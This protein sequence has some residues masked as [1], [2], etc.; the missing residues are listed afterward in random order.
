MSTVI[1]SC[2]READ[3]AYIQLAAEIPPGGVARTYACDPA[4]LGGTVNLDVDP[5]GRLVGIEVLHASEMLPP[6]ALG[7]G[8]A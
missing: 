1:I 3:A 5:E 6:E 2:D 4:E 8:R 7:I